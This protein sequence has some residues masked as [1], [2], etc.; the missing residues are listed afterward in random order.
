MTLIGCN[1]IEEQKAESLINKYYQ[2]MT[3]ADYENAFD[4]LYPYDG[5]YMDGTTMTQAEAKGFYLNKIDL[6]KEQ[7]YKLQDFEQIEVAYV[8][9]G[10]LM[11]GNSDDTYR[12][13]RDGQ[14][15]VE[16]SEQSKLI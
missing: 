15:N 5:F 9:E 14:M 12:N 1:S 13:Y 7:K 8:F 11:L 3:D 4:Q 10:K 6:L 2:A 16:V